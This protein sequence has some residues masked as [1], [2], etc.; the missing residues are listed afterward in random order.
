MGP[1][2]VGARRLGKIDIALTYQS[3]E[4][5]EAL[6]DDLQEQAGKLLRSTIGDQPRIVA[7]LAQWEIDHDPDASNDTGDT[8]SN[9]Y[10]VLAQRH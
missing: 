8:I 5:F 3:H 2:G 1:N 7:D 6:P 9:P 4:F 10:G